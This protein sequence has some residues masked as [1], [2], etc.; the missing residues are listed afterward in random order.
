MKHLTIFDLDGTV[1]N[2]DH[3]L[4]MATDKNLSMDNFCVE[5]Y[6]KTQVWEHVKNDLL[7]PLADLMRE[8]IALG[9]NVGIVTARQMRLAD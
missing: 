7:L 9:Y 2:S 4:K 8:Q 6:R 1:I 5:T 3:R